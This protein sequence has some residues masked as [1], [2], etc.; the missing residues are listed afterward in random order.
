MTAAHHFTLQAESFYAFYLI[1]HGLF[2]AALVVGLL[3]EKLWA[4]PASLV[5][6]TVFIAYQVYRYWLDHSSGLLVLT[7]L[8]ILLIALVYHEWRIVKL[9]LAKRRARCS[10]R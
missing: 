8:D 3:K 1:S 2:N 10:A 9:H 4:Y 7:G 5:V 6:L